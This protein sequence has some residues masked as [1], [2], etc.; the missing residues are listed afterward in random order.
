MKAFLY[1]FWVAVVF[2]FTTST[3]QAQ[4]QEKQASA[5]HFGYGLFLNYNLYTWHQKPSFVLANSSSGQVF[6]VLPGVGASLW[7]GDVD[8]WL[9]ALESGVEF[10]PFALDIDNYSGLGAVSFPI[11][12]K[13]QLPVAKQKSLWLMVHAGAGVQFTKTDLYAQPNTTINHPFYATIM[14]EV[15]FHISAVGYQKQHLR[16]VELFVR[17]GAA[18]LGAISVHTGLRVSFLNRF[19]K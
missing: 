15:G 18:P 8:H 16:E 7:L 5:L 14:G 2:L 10:L 1:S 12:A 3:A 17:A 6:N 19:G 11:L 4:E 9:I 13:V